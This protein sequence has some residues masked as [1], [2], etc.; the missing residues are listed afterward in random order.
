MTNLLVLCW[1]LI[2]LL[3][4]LFPLAI[5]TFCFLFPVVPV[6]ITLISPQQSHCIITPVLHLMLPNWHRLV[7]VAGSIVSSGSNHVHAGAV[8]LAYFPNGDSFCDVVRRWTD[9]GVHFT[10][11]LHFYK[12]KNPIASF[13]DNCTAQDNNFMQH[14]DR[15]FST[16]MHP[17]FNSGFILLRAPLRFRNTDKGNKKRGRGEITL[18]LVTNNVIPTRRMKE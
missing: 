8:E 5:H 7:T 4:L 9:F 18:L 10:H 17:C 11:Q 14:R 1:Y 16:G 15:G 6:V 2:V 12:A 3:F 13:K